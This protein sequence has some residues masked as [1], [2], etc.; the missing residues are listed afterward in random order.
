MKPEVRNDWRSVEALAE[1]LNAG[2]RK[3]TMSAHALR[4]YVRESHKNGL[5]PYVRRLGRKI[6][7]S[8]SG[9]HEWLS[10]SRQNAA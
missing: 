5:A 4:H 7:I 8:E 2:T 6:L 9:F 10:G 3:P 1:I